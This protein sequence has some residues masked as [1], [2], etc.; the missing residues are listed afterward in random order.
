MQVD[1]IMVTLA[2]VLAIP[3]TGGLTAWLGFLV[4]RRS[5]AEPVVAPYSCGCGHPLAMHDAD[6]GRCHGKDLHK[7][8]TTDK[9]KYIGHQLLQCECRRYVGDFPSTRSTGPR[10]LCPRGPRRPPLTWHPTT[11]RTEPQFP[12]VLRCVVR[13]SPRR[14]AGHARIFLP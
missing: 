10:W 11:A 6:T 3:V 8:V 1:P 12:R 2:A 13:T 7:N 14:W 5:A 9:G 4:G